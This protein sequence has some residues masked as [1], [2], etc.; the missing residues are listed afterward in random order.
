MMKFLKLLLILQLLL[1]VSCNE[2]VK[3]EVETI[4]EEPIEEQTTPEEVME[5]TPID[6]F[7]E[8]LVELY[9]QRQY[10]AQD[11][12][13]S[14]HYINGIDGLSAWKISFER[15]LDSS[16][17]DHVQTLDGFKNIEAVKQA[18]VKSEGTIDGQA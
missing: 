9:N 6:A 11:T 12:T 17:I 1:F 4:N 5:P 8:A 2:D 7:D 18:F 13:E 16:T 15:C 10:K 14:K 3:T